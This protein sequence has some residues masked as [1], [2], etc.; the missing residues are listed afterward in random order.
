MLTEK[1]KQKIEAIQHSFELNEIGIEEYV[2]RLAD[3]FFPLTTIPI[4]GGI[5]KGVKENE[6]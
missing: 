4:A 2:K 3:V 5:V 6:K 1:T